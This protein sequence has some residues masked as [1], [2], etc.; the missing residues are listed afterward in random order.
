MNETRPKYTDCVRN[1]ETRF[2]V[3]VE[4]EDGSIEPVGDYRTKGHATRK[5][6]LVKRDGVFIYNK[7]HI[8]RIRVFIQ[9]VVVEVVSIREVSSEDLDGGSYNR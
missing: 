2:E 7:E 9:R 6:N 5:L 4:L 1:P 3:C 8:K